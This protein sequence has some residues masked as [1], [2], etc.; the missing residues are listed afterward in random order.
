MHHLIRLM[1][2]VLCLAVGGVTAE[3]PERFLTF[4]GD[5][6][7]V[8]DFRGQGYWLILMIWSHDCPLCRREAPRYQTLHA[9]HSGGEIRILGLSLDGETEAM[10]A[11]AF[12]A[13]H[14]LEFPNLIGEPHDV[15]DFFQR[16]SGQPFLGTPS[17]LIFSPRGELKAAHAGAIDPSQIEAFVRQF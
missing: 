14:N 10:E 9:R 4:D 8:S 15:I 16:E 12:T 7:R 2:F 13:E 11:W 6:V 5:S 1:V 17:W 3:E